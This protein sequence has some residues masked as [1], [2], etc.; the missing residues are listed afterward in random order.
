MRHR[1]G[2][3]AILVTLAAGLAGGR[4]PAAEQRPVLR[5][6]WIDVQGVAPYAFPLAVQEA[7]GILDEVGISTS[8]TLGTPETETSGHAVS[9]VLLREP[10]RGA[11]LAPLTMGCTLRAGR[12][13]VTWVYLSAVLSALGLQVPGGRG[14]AREQEEIGRALGRVVAHEIVHVLVPDL[15]HGNAGLMTAHLSRARLVRGRASLSPRDADALHAAL[16][17]FNAVK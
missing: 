14:R 3:F 16:G 2:I 11:R 9:V 1:T 8:W 6:L 4:A 13:N 10:Q 7:A 12:S 17:P 5:V 15:P